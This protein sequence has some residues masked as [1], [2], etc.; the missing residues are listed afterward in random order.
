MQ[1]EKKD[2]DLDTFL[3]TI[4]WVKYYRSTGTQGELSLTGIGEPL[5]HPYFL[6]YL[7][8][9]RQI[10]PYDPIVFA[11]NGLLLTEELCKDMAH[12]KPRIYISLH[13]PELATAGIE[14]AKR[15]GLLAGV[16]TSF[17]HSAINWAG[18][19]EWYNSAPA[20]ACE[21]LRSGW[22]VVLSDGA[23]T[24]CCMDAEGKGI[25]GNTKD[26]PC[27]LEMKPY[28]LCKSCYQ[29]IPEEVSI[30]Q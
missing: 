15:Y 8:I 20:C 17:A 4:E 30:C 3:H 7:M 10:L 23:I 12:I 2:M 13:R 26:T 16:N 6:Q 19:V 24:T 27:D 1:R 21:F 14:A 25:I 29:S 22:G 28:S 11:T 18:Q 5:L 9:A